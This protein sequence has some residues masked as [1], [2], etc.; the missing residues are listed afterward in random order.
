MG[1]AQSTENYR[2]VSAPINEKFPR[3]DTMEDSV[4]VEKDGVSYDGMFFLVFKYDFSQSCASSCGR[5]LS[6]EN[7]MRHS[8]TSAQELWRL[9]TNKHVDY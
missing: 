5:T 6:N 9:Y 4:I 8:T 1:Q 2:P 3:H 7:G